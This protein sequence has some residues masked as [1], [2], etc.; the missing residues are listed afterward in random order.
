MFLC[1]LPDLADVMDL[2]AKGE[3][4][5][6]QQGIVMVPI[7]KKGRTQR[8]GQSDRE[9]VTCRARP[10][11]INSGMNPLKMYVHCARR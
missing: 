5:A 3:R 4:M 6:R 2:N 11:K 8:R 10:D 7:T 9:E 1:S